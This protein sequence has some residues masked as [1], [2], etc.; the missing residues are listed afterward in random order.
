M[1]VPATGTAQSLLWQNPLPCNSQALQNRHRP[2]LKPSP[3]DQQFNQTCKLQQFA[4]HVG[5]CKGGNILKQPGKE[6]AKVIPI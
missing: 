1:F 4:A 6:E 5:V 3:T 2:N